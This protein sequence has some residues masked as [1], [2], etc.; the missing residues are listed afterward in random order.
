MENK[1]SDAD[2]RRVRTAHRGKLDR[3]VQLHIGH[4][5]RILYDK[6]VNEG[7]PDHVAK[8]IDHLCERRNKQGLP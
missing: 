5:L 3:N 4:Q 2:R 6:V 7:I 1:L 8:L